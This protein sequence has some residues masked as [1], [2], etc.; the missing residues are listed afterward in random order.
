MKTRNPP[1]PIKAYIQKQGFI[2]SELARKLGMSR[3]ALTTYINGKGYLSAERK[4]Q[5]SEL[6]G[7]PIERFFK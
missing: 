5:L 2:I 1:T 3:Q 7:L 4:Q 6:I